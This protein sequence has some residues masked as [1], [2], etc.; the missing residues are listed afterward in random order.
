[1]EEVRRTVRATVRSLLD[2]THSL[3]SHP[4]PLVSL[5]KGWLSSTFE[6]G[7]VQRIPL[8]YANGHASGALLLDCLPDGGLGPRLP[9][10]HSDIAVLL[11][12]KLSRAPAGPTFVLL[13]GAYA[14]STCETLRKL[15]VL[16]S[17]ALVVPEGRWPGLVV[18]P[19]AGSP[20]W[21]LGGSVWLL[22]WG[23]ATSLPA[24]SPASVAAL[25]HLLSSRLWKGTL[26]LLFHWDKQSWPLDAV[27]HPC[28]QDQLDDWGILP[29]TPCSRISQVSSAGPR[30]SWL[31]FLPRERPPPLRLIA[32]DF[33]DRA[34][35]L[36]SFLD[37]VLGAGI[38]HVHS[39]YS[40]LVSQD[41]SYRKRYALARY[42][43]AP[44]PARKSFFRS[45]IGTKAFLLPSQALLN[46]A[47][48]YIA[49]T[50]ASTPSRSRVATYAQSMA[51]PTSRVPSLWLA[52]RFAEARMSTAT[53]ASL[54]P[55]PRIPPPPLPTLCVRHLC[56][57][58]RISG[59]VALVRCPSCSQ[60]RYCSR[61]CRLKDSPHRDSCSPNWSGEVEP[62]EVLLC[63][64]PLGGSW[65]LCPAGSVRYSLPPRL[66]RLHP[67]LGLIYITVA[68]PLFEASA[69]PEGGFTILSLHQASSLLPGLL[70]SQPPAP[71]PLGPV[72]GRA[73]HVFPPEPD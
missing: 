63:T 39:A 37:S 70:A 60:A 14:P 13:G 72:G 17:V 67:Q 20:T 45:W 51:I 55:V 73:H 44:P 1:M 24:P 69:P 48:A 54:A 10:D 59:R 35:E 4:I 58:C 65:S 34:K 18:P 40:S 38:A 56:V 12:S 43:G 46:Q 33:P 66:P 23:I 62:D 2:S 50:P 8:H 16:F 53:R 64:R 61:A 7:S 52:I 11:L 71:A 6:L 30:R 22:S 31:G 21:F 26:E 68:D 19:V 27:G 3:V 36:W 9:E 28:L 41:L 5:V 49:A 47:V 32:A 15:K 25:S 57:S 29:A 42:R